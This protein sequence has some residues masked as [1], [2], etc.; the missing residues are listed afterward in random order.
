MVRADLR[1]GLVIA[2]C[3]VGTA[4]GQT[5]EVMPLDDDAVTLAPM[6]PADSNAEI[7]LDIRAVE[8]PGFGP[9]FQLSDEQFQTFEQQIRIE[10]AEAGRLRVLDKMTGR[11]RDLTL[12]SAESSDLGRIVVTLHECRYPSE[13][14]SSDAYARVSVVS[15][16]GDTLFTGWMIAS[17]PALMALD[18]PRYDVWVLG[19]TLPPDEDPP[20]LTEDA[21]IAPQVA[22]VGAQMLTQSI[23]PR[24]RP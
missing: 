20:E 5:I 10:I 24:P 14:P 19:C 21:V 3:C 18:H 22:P 1:T 12:M 9:R 13:S 2:A 23:R 7:G 17:S 4:F 8:E 6:D 11:T 15:N 16:T